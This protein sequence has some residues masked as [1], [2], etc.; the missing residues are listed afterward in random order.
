MAP[1]VLKVKGNENDF[2][3]FAELDNDDDLARAWKTCSKVKDTLENGNR[4]ENLS[5]RLW[6]LHQS[7]YR[8]NDLNS[9]QFRKIS[10]K[11]TRKLDE[12]DAKAPALIGRPKDFGD[13]RTCNTFLGVGHM[14]SAGLSAHPLHASQRPSLYNVDEQAIPSMPSPETPVFASAIEVVQSLGSV[15]EDC[16]EL[17]WDALDGHSDALFDEYIRDSTTGW[18]ASMI[19]SPKLATT[20]DIS[21]MLP[22]TWSDTSPISSTLYNNMT[23]TS[24]DSLNSSTTVPITQPDASYSAHERSLLASIF[25][26]TSFTPVRPVQAQQPSIL[27]TSLYLPDNATIPTSS[28]QVGQ[29]PTPASTPPTSSAQLP[30]RTTAT[31]RPRPV[32]TPSAPRTVR[33][34][35]CAGNSDGKLMCENCGVTSTPLWRRSANDELLCNACGLYL[36]LHNT[37]RPKNLK[38]SS[39]KEQSE[40]VVQAEC[41]NCQTKTTPLWRRDDAGNNLCNACGLYLKLHNTM[42]PLSM[43]TDVIRKRQRYDNGLPIR[44]KRSKG[45]TEIPS[46]TLNST[47]TLMFPAVNSVHPSPPMEDS[48]ELSFSAS[49]SGLMGI[50]A[51]FGQ[52]RYAY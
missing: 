1:L 50:P 49:H 40:E 9:R 6:H 46:E 41:Y 35:A 7:M 10:T 5:W 25:S 34:V 8:A 29:N 42:R 30:E 43:K 52:T 33:N 37:N 12:A 36:K 2:S 14:E 20:P 4:L 19:G 16:F 13:V 21:D 23:S 22:S 38:A 3:P 18:S 39:R 51:S 27:P 24:P 48:N 17:S 45:S 15:T 47:P 28:K 11:A 44:K 32:P 26:D 31:Y